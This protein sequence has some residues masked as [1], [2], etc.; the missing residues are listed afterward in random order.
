MMALAGRW[1]L[2]CL[3][4]APEPGLSFPAVPAMIHSLF[5]S[6]DG[7]LAHDLSTEQL[8]QALAQPGGTLWLDLVSSPETRQQLAGLL[9]EL[10]G[11]HPLALDD[12]FQEA[13]VP[14]VDDWG[15]YLFI[16]LHAAGRPADGLLQTL[17]VDAFL[18]PNYLVTVREGPVGPLEHLWDQCRQ[19]AGQRLAS[20]PDRLLYA[21]A[22]ALAADYLAAVEGLD[23]D[24]EHVEQAVFRRPGPRLVARLF[25][26]RRSLVRLRR[27]LGSLREVMNRLARDDFAVVAAASRVYFRDVYDHLVRLYDIVEGLR[28]MAAGALE[29]Y[30]SVTSYRLNEVMRTLTV[31]TVLFLP[32]NFLAGFFGMNFFGEGLAVALPVP[33]RPLFWLCLGLMALTPAAMFWWIAR[34]GM[35][36][37]ADRGKAAQTRA[38][39]TTA[40]GQGDREEDR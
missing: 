18:G 10:F 40:K 21:L 22:D 30:L 17:E 13:H 7:T 4:A 20:G 6:H 34:R 38:G 15:D 9:G 32:L 28:D 11:F 3:Q 8:R 33:G 36:A 23:D 5:R 14:R 16:V 37:P 2:R 1:S 39:G 31:V 25:R 19:G 35:L 27:V 12:A 26:V 24:I 29:S